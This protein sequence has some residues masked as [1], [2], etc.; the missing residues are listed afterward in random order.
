[1]P[2]PLRIR[3]YR[4]FLD[5]LERRLR[6]LVGKTAEARVEIE[7]YSAAEQE[8]ARRSGS[9]ARWVQAQGVAA[10]VWP[11]AIAIGAMSPYT[12]F[13]QERA[14]RVGPKVREMRSGLARMQQFREAA[15]PTVPLLDVATRARIDQR[16]GQSN[17]AI[18]AA[19][20]LVDSWRQSPAFEFDTAN[21]DTL[22]RGWRHLAGAVGSPWQIFWPS[23]P[24]VVGDIG[25]RATRAG[26]APPVEPTTAERIRVAEV[27]AGIVPVAGGESE[28]V[29]SGAGVI[30]GAL[31]LL[32][33]GLGVALV[34]KNLAG[35]RESESEES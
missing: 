4:E 17:E 25:A 33:L 24:R 6:Y 29:A 2:E 27:E 8:R 19:L 11:V 21:A 9:R 26:T 15:Q 34:V 30:V 5:L 3:D 35:T 28:Q 22:T 12:R 18:A 16:I 23:A 32:G 20:R 14:R 13:D 31:I 10:P 1:M 7:R